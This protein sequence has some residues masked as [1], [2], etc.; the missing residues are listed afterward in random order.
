MRELTRRAA[1]AAVAGVAGVSAA[2]VVCEAAA[3]PKR[4]TFAG[5]GLA[6]L[7]F[8]AVLARRRVDSWRDL[9][10]RADNLRAAA[11][12]VALATAVM[13]AGVLA[14]GAAAARLRWNSEIAWLLAVYPPWALVQQLA[15]QGVLHRR[16]QVVIGKPAVEVLLTSACFAAVHAGDTHLVALTFAAGVVWSLLFRRA[17]NLWLLAASHA[18]LAALAYPVVLADAPLS[19]M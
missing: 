14:W 19:R 16:L 13:A 15:F 10:L 4:W 3:V 7:V 11:G 5:A 6:L 8:V 2:Y 18:V 1:W 9:G 12:P 17:P